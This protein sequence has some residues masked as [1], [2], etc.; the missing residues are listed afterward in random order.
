MKNS[1]LAQLFMQAPVAICIVSGPQYVVELVN[2]RMLQ[3][4]GRNE[5]I[6]G[7]PLQQSLTEVRE[8]GLLTI[9]EKV[10]TT[11]RSSYISNFPAVILINGIREARYFN[12]AFKPYYVIQGETVPTGIF[13]VAHNVTDAVLALQK[14]EEEKQRTAL[15]LETGELGMLAT[16]WNSHTAT[17]DKRTNEIFGLEGVQPLEAYLSETAKVCSRI[18]W[19]VT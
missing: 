4:L 7:H 17:A 19:V 8:Q 6:V 5:G 14:L 1:D 18:S 13:C 2:E 15:A 16:D 12:L 11:G 10:R 9:L 3:F